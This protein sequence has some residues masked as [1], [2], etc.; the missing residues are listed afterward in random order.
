MLGGDLTLCR[1]GDCSALVPSE[2]RN[3]SRILKYVKIVSWWFY[4]AYRITDRIL[5]ECIL[6]LVFMAVAIIHCRQAV[7]TK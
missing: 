1:D 7:P 3:N 6:V 4:V 5:K 2:D